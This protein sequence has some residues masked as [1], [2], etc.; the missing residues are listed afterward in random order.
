MIAGAVA[1]RVKPAVPPR[2]PGRVVQREPRFPGS[3]P[4]LWKVPARNPHFTGRSGE[5]EELARLLRRGTGR[6]GTGWGGAA[7]ARG[8][9]AAPPPPARTIARGGSSAAR[10]PAL[11][12]DESR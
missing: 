9:A 7:R 10:R 4:R 3:L 2:F 12:R 11:S 5:L 8:R 6:W 1:G